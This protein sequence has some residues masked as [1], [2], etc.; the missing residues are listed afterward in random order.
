MNE[1]CSTTDV[2]ALLDDEYAR[3]I[4]IAVSKRPMSAKELGDE[5]EMSLPTVYR[6]IE[7]LIGAGLVAERTKIAADGHHYSMYE[8]CLQRLTVEL[9]NGNLEI[10]IE[11]QPTDDV[12]DRF[13]EMW[14]QV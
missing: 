1:D 3:T 5:C 13:T 9:T 12:A 8:A 7:R 6:R 10:V 4:L 2:F 14:N 11:T